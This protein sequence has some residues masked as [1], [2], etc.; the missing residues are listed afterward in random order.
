[1]YY[2]ILKKWYKMINNDMLDNVE[3]FL[4]YIKLEKKLSKNT[5]YNYYLDLIDFVEYLKNNDINDLND[6]LETTIV[7]YL[8]YLKENKKLN[9][10]SIEL[11]E[12]FLNT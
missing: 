3:D 9:T 2:V 11:L 5:F 6:V 8:E 12:I 10:R 1:M 4:S 7:N